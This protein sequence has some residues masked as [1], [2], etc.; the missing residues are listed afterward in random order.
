MSVSVQNSGA[1]GRYAC[2]F[3]IQW[4]QSFQ[5][6]YSG[7]S[8][9]LS[10]GC[11]T[12]APVIWRGPSGRRKAGRPM[13]LSY[14]G[15]HPGAGRRADPC[16]C[17]MAGTIRAPDGGMIRTP[18]GGL[19]HVPVRWQDHP[20][21]QTRSLYSR[22]VLMDEKKPDLAMLIRDILYQESLSSYARKAASLA[23][24]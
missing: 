18:D 5:N 10:S 23:W 11:L 1:P 14:G 6:R 9:C 21:R 16:A 12:H 13:R 4:K 7:R 20:R 17:H 24:T 3:T 15:D 19:I 22:A 8:M 2:I